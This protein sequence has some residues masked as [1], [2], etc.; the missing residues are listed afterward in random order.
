MTTYKPLWLGKDFVFLVLTTILGECPQCVSAAVV[1]VK[2][3]EDGII[4]RRT[5]SKVSLNDTPL[6]EIEASFIAPDIT[7]DLYDE[8]TLFGDDDEW[9]TFLAKLMKTE[10]TYP[11]SCSLVW[12][13]VL[14]LTVRRILI[15]NHVYFVSVSIS[16]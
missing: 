4:A 14:T 16:W 12:T 13:L 8:S 11:A 5:R 3:E 7:P 15:A 6:D 2:T 9:Q 10:G 1:K